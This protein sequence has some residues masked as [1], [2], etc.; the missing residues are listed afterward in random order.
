MPTPNDMVSAGACFVGMW[1]AAYVVLEL[2]RALINRK[3][4]KP[5]TG[6][7]LSC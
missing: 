6:E 2:A 5:T 4:R 7:D 3:N 1:G